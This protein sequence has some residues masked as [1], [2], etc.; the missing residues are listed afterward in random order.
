MAHVSNGNFA[1]ESTLGYSVAGIIFIYLAEGIFSME[2]LNPNLM[3]VQ[4]GVFIVLLF[5]I[6]NYSWEQERNQPRYPLPRK[7]STSSF[8][9]RGK[10]SVSTIALFT[11]LL[12]SLLRTLDMTLGGGHMGY[13]GNQSR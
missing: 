8:D 3:Q 13:K 11:Q 12:A 10:L 1:R 6:M 5:A 2:V 9:R 4:I 7:L